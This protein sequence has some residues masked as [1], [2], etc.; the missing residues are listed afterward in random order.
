MIK[1]KKKN[2]IYNLTVVLNERRK[3]MS[4]GIPWEIWEAAAEAGKQN[5]P[6]LPPLP[7]VPSGS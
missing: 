5:N 3:K 4:F 1:K 2:C 6:T 7:M